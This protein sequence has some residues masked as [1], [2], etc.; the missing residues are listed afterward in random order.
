LSC[1]LEEQLLELALNW[2][3]HCCGCEFRVL[4]LIKECHNELTSRKI[5]LR[6]KLFK[7][8][9]MNWEV[10]PTHAY[11]N[12]SCT[13][14][15]TEDPSWSTCFETRRTQK[16]SSTLEA[17]WKTLFVLYLYLIGTFPIPTTRVHKDH[18]VEQIIGDL[19]S[20]PKTRRMTKNLEEHEPKKVIQALQDPSRIEAMQDELLQFKLQKNEI[21]IMIKNKAR[22][23]AQG[24]TQ[25]EGIDYDEVFAPVARIEAIRLF[26]AYASF[27]DFVVYQMDV[28]SAFLYGKIE[29]EVYVCQP[30]GFEDPDFPDRVYKVE[31]ALY[32]LHQAPRAW[33]ETLSTY[34]LDNGFQ[35]GK[36]DKT[37][38]IRRDKGDILLVQVYVDDIIF[39]STKK[40]LCTE[41]EKMMHK[42]FQMSSM[43]ELTFF[44]GLQVKQ[45]EDGIFISQD[46]YVTE[47]L[48]KFGFTDVKTA[49][50]PMETQKPLLKDEDGEE[51]DVHLYRSM[52]GSL[53][54]LT[55]S[56]PDIMFA[57]CACAR[58]QV[59]PKVSHLHAVKRIFRYLKGQPK[60]G[61][62]YPKDSPFDLVAYTDSDYAGA[63]LDRKSTTGG[64]QFLGC[65]LISWQCKKQTVVA[66]SKQNLN[67]W[68]FNL[69][70]DKY[71][72]TKL[73]ILKQ[74]EYDMW[75]LRIDQY[76]QFQ[77]YAL[78][79]VI[80]N[81][82]SFKPGART[83]T[84]ADG[85]PPHTKTRIEVNKSK[86]N[87]STY[88]RRLQSVE[89]Q[90]VN[91]ERMRPSMLGCRPSKL[92]RASITLK[93]IINIE[94]RADPKS[95]IAWSQKKT[96]ILIIKYSNHAD[97]LDDETKVDK[98]NNTKPHIP[99]PFTPNTRI[100]KHHSLDHVIGDVHSGV[101][102]R[103][104]TKTINEQGFISAVYEGKSH[105][106][107]HT[108]LF[109]CF[110]SKEEPR[111]ISK[112][113]IDLPKGKRAIG[114]KW[115]FRNKKD[116]R[117]MVIRN[118]ARLV[119]QGHTQEE[120]MDYD[121]VFI[122]RISLSVSTK[123]LRSRQSR[124]SQ[125]IG[126]SNYGCIKH[127]EPV[128]KDF[129]TL[130]NGE[131]ELITTIDGKVK[132]IIKASVRRHLKLADADGISSLP[133]TKIFDKISLMG[134][135]GS[136]RRQ[137]TIGDIPAQTRFKRLSKQSNKPPLSR[138][139]TLGSGED[140]M[141]LQELMDLCIKL[142]DKVLDLDNVKNAQ[143]LEIQKLMKGVKK[144]EKS[145]AK[146]SLGNQE[147]A[148][149]QGRNEI[150]Q[151]E[152]IS[153]FQEDSETQGRYGYDIGVNT[154]STSIT[155][156]SINITIVEPVTT[157]SAPITTTSVSVSTAEPSTPPTITI[158]TTVIEDEDL[159]I[160]QTLMKMTSEKSKEKS[161]EKGVSI[162]TATRLARG[163]IVKEASETATRP[164]VP[165]PQIDPKDKGKGIIQEPKKPVKVKGKDQIEYDA[166]VAQRL[167][168]KI[169]K[170]ARLEREREEQASKASNI[171]EWD[172]VQAM[173]DEDY[174]L[175]AKL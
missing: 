29:E 152:G 158:T 11:Y 32:G 95:E 148:S 59:N 27:K 116:E 10:N 97:I 51:V 22:L 61:L 112:A 18:P 160:A 140:S 120:G 124:Q 98:S 12:G 105:E 122:R 50:T 72:T 53:M 163:V 28:K 68:C 67:M 54:Y 82:N 150:D 90:L 121:E 52:I 173:M 138:V 5:N 129:R 60:L 131:I 86:F 133:T 170:E 36:I 159:I 118:K 111:R 13:I 168:A 146:K 104:M 15:D 127:Q 87:I 136:P 77:D 155:T 165:P 17:L 141:K 78:W 142:S 109:A 56:R 76:F 139:N 3:V 63:S 102:T 94:A 74:G 117:V 58:Y 75:R 151:D 80:E 46:K 30:P 14:K 42:K 57:V 25:E 119:A 2:A 26:L 144:L 88:E 114:T 35:R 167:Q 135:F 83:T 1:L 79:D 132:T 69:P 123:W 62:W 55:S 38:F 19:N 154:A 110:L 37:L 64:C 134:S 113:L 174:E 7:T 169:D 24:Y 91:T 43:G 73:P 47:I 16:T 33:Y 93:S 143:A 44:L 164:T 20:A 171:A 85:T 147:D 103:R 49:S 41:F 125:R 99:I 4:D 108:C 137:D 161:K 101:Q 6:R 70:M 100:H 8:C 31:K 128:K 175:A 39:G 71:L 48:K 23:V 34:L 40:S 115:I 106:D 153:W 45:K 66:N 157:A 149:K 126:E 9:C 156:S 81:G 65:R 96:N 107:L 145:S 84:N 172:D 162:D 166:D 92:E 21:G 130:D 89:E